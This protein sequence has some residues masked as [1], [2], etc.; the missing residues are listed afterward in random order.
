MTA[1]ITSLPITKCPRFNALASTLQTGRLRGVSSR[2]K[3][4]AL[5]RNR[6]GVHS[7]STGSMKASM[8][9]ACTREQ[10]GWGYLMARDY[11]GF[12]LDFSDYMH[13]NGVFRITYPEEVLYEKYPQPAHLFR[14]RLSDKKAFS[15]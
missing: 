13:S 5:Y 4:Q 8:T 10:T 12:S 15:W 3:G 14:I 9:G 1:W 7:G 11:G 6:Y 2:P